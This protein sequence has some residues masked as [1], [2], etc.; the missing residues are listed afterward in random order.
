MKSLL[1]TLAASALGTFAALAGAPANNS[2]QIFKG[3]IKS[4]FDKLE[5]GASQKGSYSTIVY[6]IQSRSE[7][8]ETVIGINPSTK[9]FFIENT[10]S[11]TF[12]LANNN[13]NLFNLRSIDL[14]DIFTGTGS[15]TGATTTATFSGVAVDFHTP[16]L[17]YQF[18]SFGTAP[19]ALY[20]STHDKAT[21]K[22]EKNLMKRAYEGGATTLA[23]ARNEVI[24]FLVE[25]GYQGLP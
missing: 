17:A 21:L 20:L 7:S 23:D 13:K 3:T 22:I 2:V 14:R 9:A 8:T 6:Y 10:G 5:A 19:G 25:K 4:K 16:K 1:L 11:A 18:D 24:A 12:T 15:L